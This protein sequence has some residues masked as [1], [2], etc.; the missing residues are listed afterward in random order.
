MQKGRGSVH[1][2]V[3]RTPNVVCRDFESDGDV[4]VRIVQKDLGCRAAHRLGEG[5]RGSAVK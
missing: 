5:H 2:S 1:E 3:P 4:P